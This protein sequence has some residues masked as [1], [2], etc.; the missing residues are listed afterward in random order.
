MEM[1]CCPSGWFPPPTTFQQL[2]EKALQGLHWKSFLLYPDDA[3]VIAPNCESHTQRLEE[4]LR[5][6][7]QAG[8]KLKPAACELLKKGTVLWTCSECRKGRDWL[9]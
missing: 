8:L 4:A 6:L 2:M 9:E 1:E 7:R 5:R 3:I